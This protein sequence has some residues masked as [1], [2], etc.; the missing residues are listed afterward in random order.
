MKNMVRLSNCPHPPK[1]RSGVGIGETDTDIANAL[2]AHKKKKTRL[3]L[4]EKELLGFKG[5]LYIRHGFHKKIKY[6]KT[7]ESN[8]R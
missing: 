2:L 7:N 4:P 3:T 5:L 1:K 6:P 8:K